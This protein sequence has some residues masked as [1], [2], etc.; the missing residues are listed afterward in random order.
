ME[1]IA[2]CHYLKSG[3]VLETKM[4]DKFYFPHRSYQEFLVSEYIINLTPDLS[5]IERIK[6]TINREILDFIKESGNKTTLISIY[7]ILSD[8]QGILNVHFLELLAWASKDASSA[9]NLKCEWHLIIYF[10]GLLLEEGDNDKKVAE[11]ILSA[12][13]TNSPREMT[14]S[15][16][17]CMCLAI[18]YSSSKEIQNN[19]L[20]ALAAVT[21]KL[22]LPQIETIVA[23]KKR[24]KIALQ[25]GTNGAWLDIVIRGI[26]SATTA[27]GTIS[28]QIDLLRIFE[29][30]KN[31][32]AHKFK[33]IG[34]EDLID[35]KFSF[36]IPTLSFAD[37]TLSMNSKGGILA[38]Y[39]KDHHRSQT[40][41]PV[42]QKKSTNK[43][44][45][46]WITS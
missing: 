44:L 17:Y 11:F 38:K 12:I 6:S 5:V 15:A 36:T 26:S 8:Y 28:L 43:K 19:L 34:F 27:D 13:D 45:P 46:D 39:F 22:S 21:L 40:L 32:L 37:E 33:I 24:A 10:Y 14:L 18:S 16:L 30:V 41:I 25:S 9:N 29:S 23:S 4:A 1:G 35:K 7:D 2:A 42:T 3:S 20:I 31:S